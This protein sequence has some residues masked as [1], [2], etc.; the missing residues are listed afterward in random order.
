MK[1]Y[2]FYTSQ[3]IVMKNN[4]KH[5]TFTLIELLVVIAI[6]AIL[7][8]MLMPALQKAKEKSQSTFCAN[9]LK[10]LVSVF[11]L[12][13]DDYK[14]TPC[15]SY[16]GLGS[17]YWHW[18]PAVYLGYTSSWQTFEADVWKNAKY[19]QA[20]AWKSLRC[21]SDP[22]MQCNE[23]GKA[24]PNYG[25]NAV[26]HDNNLTFDGHGHDNG[27]GVR[28]LERIKQPSKI[29]WLIDGGYN[30]DQYG[31]VYVSFR[32]GYHSPN[33]DGSIMSAGKRHGG[34]LNTVFGDGH[35]AVTTFTELWTEYSNQKNNI[36][37][38]FFD[39]DQ[40]K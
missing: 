37:S 16:R 18:I 24:K 33:I 1:I 2:Q 28:K 12:Y 11:Q 31:S 29:F 21:P 40:I 34:F 6:I 39:R 22:T 9:N 3:E 23:P 26:H 38:T 5:R 20:S 14:K 25:L 4:T 7:A 30:G 27:M 15:A 17:F 8:A 32:M 36:Y 10:Q 13:H 19:R 35:Y